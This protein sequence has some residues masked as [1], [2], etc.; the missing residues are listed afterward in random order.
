MYESENNLLNLQNSDQILNTDAKFSRRD[1]L[2]LSVT[3][4]VASLVPSEMYAAA[5]EL[6]PERIICLHNVYTLETIETVFW[7]E[8]D[9]L[10]EA[11]SDINHIFRD[12]RSGKER[13]ISKELINLLYDLQQEV[14]NKEPFQIVSGYRSPRSNALLRRTTKGVAKNSFH[15][16]GK[17]VDIRL[18]DYSLSTLRRKAMNLRGGGVGF[19]PRSNF[20]HVDVGAVRYWKG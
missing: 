4:A 16:Y 11:L 20:I 9:Y 1:F 14:K 8:G 17:A 2:A 19:Y 12:T 3:A 15:M 18:P 5:E 13:T 10:P 6:Q 7:K